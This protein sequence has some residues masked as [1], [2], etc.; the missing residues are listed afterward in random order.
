MD[1]T[2]RS[3]KALGAGRIAVCVLLCW[4]ACRA[5]GPGAAATIAESRP[6]A[7]SWGKA[8]DGLTCRL[9]VPPALCVGEP[10]YPVV[11]IRN[12]SARR[13]YLV[14]LFD[15]HYTKHAKMT[16]VGPDGRELKQSSWSEAGLNPNSLKPLEPNEVRRIELLELSEWFNRWVDQLRPP[17]QGRMV[18]L[19]TRPGTYKLTYAYQGTKLPK[20]MVVGE[21]TKPD[22]S[23]ENIYAELT[24]DQVANTWAG[25]L[26][27]NTAELVV[28]RPT[29]DDLHVH[30]W[31]VMT[32]YN[33]VKYANAGRK[34]EW[35]SLP[36][37]FYRQFPTRRLRWA[38]LDV[39]KPVIYFYSKRPCL[40]LTVQ[41]DFRGGAPVVWWP[42]CSWPVD[43]GVGGLR[44]VGQGDKHFQSL[45]WLAWL[46]RKVPASVGPFGPLSDVT[47][48]R[49]E[50]KEFELP[51]ACWLTEARLK[52][53][54]LVT[55]VGSKLQRGRPWSTDRL[56]T[57][58]FLFY[59]GLI[60]APDY[61]RCVKTEAGS[62]AFT[63]EANFAIADL[64]LVDRRGVADAAAPSYA[65][66][67]KP[68]PP[69]GR[70][71]L[72]PRR[73][74]AKD[75][76][77]AT[78]GQVRKAL[79]AAG[80]YEAEADALLKIWHKGLFDRPGVTAF[81]VLPQKQY[82]A[83]L[84]LRIHPQP[85]QVVR[86]GLVLHPHAEHDPTLAARVA[87]LIGKL[88]DPTFKVREQATQDLAELGPPAFGLIRKALARPGPDDETRTRLRKVLDSCDAMEFL[89]PSSKDKAGAAPARSR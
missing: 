88:A 11:E 47:G 60:P 16:I 27:S 46:G 41:V 81:Y 62:L 38:P 74:D 76:P 33:D 10:I 80:L 34:A 23:I 28:R 71:T 58:R 12:V 55:T 86:V 61:L 14:S 51:A 53:A 40:K 50:V 85:N 21:R 22:G 65:N 64:F 2:S 30:E 24:D 69:G 1:N 36:E 66:A 59:D 48:Q 73:I 17:P 84:P 68:I 44:Q 4:S 31:G 9:T 25:K 89:K 8:V 54:S 3:A 6:A 42:A 13:L 20:R 67:A 87:A 78:V 7:A 49:L 45:V 72:R 5:A 70:I 32:V 52:D 26:V 83:M 63:N 56:E 79:V 77:T 75:W 82:D 19:L 29:R 39:D 35:G 43:Q 15:F 57:E 37:F 18:S